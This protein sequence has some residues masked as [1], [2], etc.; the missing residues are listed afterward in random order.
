MLYILGA[1]GDT[2]NMTEVEAAVRKLEKTSIDKKD[3]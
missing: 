3:N 1:F 2:A